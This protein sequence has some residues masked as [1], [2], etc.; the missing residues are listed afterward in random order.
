MVTSRLL[1]EFCE[2]EFVKKGVNLRHYHSGIGQEALSVAGAFVLRKTDYLYY[3]PVSYTH[4]FLH[5]V[6][7][8]FISLTKRALLI[9]I[10]NK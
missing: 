9:S 2:N 10:M 1:D 4:L 5:M 6:L 3:T 7:N 8:P